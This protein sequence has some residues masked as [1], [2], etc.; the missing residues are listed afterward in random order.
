MRCAR[1]FR[2]R[3]CSAVPSADATGDE[4]RGHRGAARAALPEGLDRGENR[5]WAAVGGRGA[6]AAARAEPS[7]AGVDRG[8]VCAPAQ[9]ASEAIL[10]ASSCDGCTPNRRGCCGRALLM[11][12]IIPHSDLRLRHARRD[13]LAHLEIA[14]HDE[15]EGAAADAVL[16]PR[17]RA[18]ANC[19]SLSL[20]LSSCLWPRSVRL[21]RPHSQTLV[22]GRGCT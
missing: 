2:R 11:L 16:P 14:Q 10:A 5:G 15:F 20:Y 6:A 13:H 22:G 8:I 9:P 18:A 4:A 12:I 17:Q 21:R 1:R 19:R 7:R 3:L